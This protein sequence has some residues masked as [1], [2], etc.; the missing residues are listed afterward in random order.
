MSVSLPGDPHTSGFWPG[1]WML[2]NLGRAGYKSTTDGLWP[3]SYDTCDQ[4]VKPDQGDKTISGLI[5]QKLNK[6]V[7]DGED[8]PSP[9]TGRGAPEIDIIEA[10]S[11]HSKGG[12][13]SQSFQLAPFDKG[14]TVNPAGTQFFPD[15]KTT[16]NTY[17]GGPLQQAVSAL[18]SLPSNIYSGTDFITFSVEYEPGDDGYITWLI[19]NKPT[20]TIKASAIAAN[21]D[22][23]V[24]KRLIPEEPMYLILNLALAEGFSEISSDLKF[25]G[26]FLIDYVRIY[27]HPDRVSITCDPPNYPTTD[28][29][30]KH[31]NAYYNKNWTTW[32]L[33]GYKKPS[34]D[35]EKCKKS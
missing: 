31:R 16:L 27:Q 17:N 7:C 32:E 9:G 11:S 23:K 35:L 33:A 5:G 4:G 25:P 2:G 26:H 12:E 1:A 24:D 8:H 18:S 29:I 22:S 34:Y 28:Y 3:Y 21:K 15:F 20:W 14:R 10:L 6:C 19:D 30:D 13:V